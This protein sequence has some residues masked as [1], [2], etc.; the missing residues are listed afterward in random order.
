MKLSA[1]LKR[2]YIFGIFWS[3]LFFS[4][5]HW[6]LYQ[7]D[8]RWPIIVASAITYGTGY[9]VTGYLFGKRD[10]QSK[11]RYSLDYWYSLSGTLTSTLVGGAW[12]L[13]F[14]RDG[15]GGLVV[16]VAI[17]LIQI[18]LLRLLTRSTIKG[19]PRQELFK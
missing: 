11:V 7:P 6:C 9:S 10:D 14:K 12:V 15:W 2:A 18:T 17:I 5:L 16:I 4:V 3:V 1:N 19:M 13:I 8:Q